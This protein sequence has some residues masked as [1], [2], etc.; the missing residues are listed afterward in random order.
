MPARSRSEFKF[1]SKESKRTAIREAEAMAADYE[2]A[3]LRCIAYPKKRPSF[4]EEMGVDLSDYEDCGY[5]RYDEELAARIDEDDAEYIRQYAEDMLTVWIVEHCVAA[6]R[7]EKTRAIAEDMLLRGQKAEDLV[8][9]YGVTA[10]TLRAKRKQVILLM[11]SLFG[12]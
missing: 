2:G 5:I 11:A 9:K 4:M 7:N 10:H 3:K 1:S 12:P 6:M 8:E